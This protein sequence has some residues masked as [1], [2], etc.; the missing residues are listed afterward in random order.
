MHRIDRNFVY[1]F[2]A[3]PS[4]K[5]Y[6]GNGLLQYINYKE[7]I[8]WLQG[9]G[10]NKITCLYTVLYKS[11]FDIQSYSKPSKFARASSSKSMATFL[12]CCWIN[13]IYILVMHTDFSSCSGHEIASALR[14]TT[15]C[16]S[17]TRRPMNCHGPMTDWG[18]LKI[19]HFRMLHLR[20]HR[21]HRKR[22]QS[23]LPSSQDK[24]S[25]FLPIHP[26][27]VCLFLLMVSDKI[28][29]FL[30]ILPRHCHPPWLPFAEH[31]HWSGE[32]IASQIPGRQECLPPISS[33]IRSAFFAFCW[34]DTNWIFHSCFLAPLLAAVSGH[35]QKGLPSFS[36]DLSPLMS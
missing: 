2:Q 17:R 22:F 25:L 3:L 28:C 16:H 4:T 11:E 12:Y 34:T 20:G 27:K 35:L 5:S 33:S 9:L 6:F 31:G 23:A 24:V 36:G 32:G 19:R 7:T 21:E 8:Y 29:V 14:W 10:N 13:L 15:P 18:R 1:I 30:V 26:D